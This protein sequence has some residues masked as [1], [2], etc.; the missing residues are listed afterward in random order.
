[1]ILMITLH[2]TSILTSSLK[3][4]LGHHTILVNGE[5]QMKEWC[6][7]S[8]LTFF[9]LPKEGIRVNIARN[10]QRKLMGNDVL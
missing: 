2:Q 8:S 5:A 3:N 1:M 9:F 6:R 7:F 4:I 10:K